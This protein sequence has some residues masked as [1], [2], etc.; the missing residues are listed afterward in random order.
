MTETTSRV[1]PLEGAPARVE[2]GWRISLPVRAE[3]VTLSKDTFVIERVV[4]RKRH[5]G[6]VR[7][8]EAELRREQLVTSR[9]GDVVITE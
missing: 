6:E 4:V 1:L 5:I 3:Q 8:A 2:G 9:Q 7:R